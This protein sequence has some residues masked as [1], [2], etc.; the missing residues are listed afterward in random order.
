MKALSNALGVP[1]KNVV[2]LLVLLVSEFGSGNRLRRLQPSCSLGPESG[3][4]DACLKYEIA[5]EVIV[6]SSMDPDLVVE[7]ADRIAE[8]GTAESQVFRQE[9]EATDGVVQARK[10]QTKISAHIVKDETKTASPSAEAD[11]D[12]DNLAWVFAILMVVFG[13]LLACIYHNRILLQRM[14]VPVGKDDGQ[15]SKSPE[16]EAD[17]VNLINGAPICQASH[18]QLSGG[19]DEKAKAVKGDTEDLEGVVISLPSPSPRT[20]L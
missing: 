13:C 2:K 20:L 9:L 14:M 7:K 10:V 17:G 8:W 4:W 19:G 15:T 16:G 11:Q 18:A 5:Y 1:L 3:L 6:P 12:N